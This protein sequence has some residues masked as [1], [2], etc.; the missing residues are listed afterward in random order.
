MPTRIS[1]TCGTWTRASATRSGFGV[2]RGEHQIWTHGDIAVGEDVDDTSSI[3]AAQRHVVIGKPDEC[4]VQVAVGIAGDRIADQPHLFVPCAQPILR[5][6]SATRLTWKI[7]WTSCQ[8][9]RASTRCICRPATS[10]RPHHPR[11]SGDNRGPI[12]VPHSVSSAACF[13]AA[14]LACARFSGRPGCPG[15]TAPVWMLY[16][17]DWYSIRDSSQ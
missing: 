7:Y 14:D 11:H 3:A 12:N 5:F 16:V 2:T 15:S 1:A 9:N 10:P 8:R 17:L 4:Q 13:L 6:R